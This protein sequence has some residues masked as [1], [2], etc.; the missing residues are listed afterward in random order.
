MH[1]TRQI[2]RDASNLSF[3]CE[4]YENFLKTLKL[5][6]QKIVTAAKFGGDLK[7]IYLKIMSLF[8]T[9]FCINNNDKL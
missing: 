6:M 9:I 1:G 8:A 3:F 2:A 5:K 4:N 7:T